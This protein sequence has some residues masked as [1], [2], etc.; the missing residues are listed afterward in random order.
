MQSTERTQPFLRQRDI[1]FVKLDGTP[2]LK[3][4]APVKSGIIARGETSG[5]MHRLSGPSLND[6]ALL[7]LMENA[8]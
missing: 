5:H 4:A 3:G 7:M 8:M 6:G 1:Y 2:N